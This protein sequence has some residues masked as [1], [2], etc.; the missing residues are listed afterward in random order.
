MGNVAAEGLLRRL[1]PRLNLP[2][3]GAPTEVQGTTPMPGSAVPP[4]H[5]YRSNWPSMS[6]LILRSGTQRLKV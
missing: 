4:L 5:P 6:E 1:T 3:S 2:P